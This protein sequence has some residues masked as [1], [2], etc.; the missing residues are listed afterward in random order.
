[1][2]SG[3]TLN[4]P[5]RYWM[6]NLSL[7]HFSF[8]LYSLG[9]GMSARLLSPRM[10]MR[11]W[12]STVTRRSG[13]PSVNI[14]A[15]SSAQATPSAS[16]SMGAYLDSARSTWEPSPEGSCSASGGPA[17]LGPS[18]SSL[19]THRFSSS[20]RTAELHPSPSSQSPPLL[21]GTPSGVWGSSTTS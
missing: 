13:H 19:S 8:S 2:Q 12:W 4:F 14:L 7:M 16:P 21:P 3:P 18:Y 10:G 15:F 11:D 20:R 6:S 5:W 9:L 17:S 1:M